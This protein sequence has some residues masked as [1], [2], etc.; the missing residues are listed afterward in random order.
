MF[1]YKTFRHCKTKFLSM[2]NL[3]N[4]P[5][6]LNLFRYRMFSESQHKRVPL[7]K[8]WHSETRKLSMENLDNPIPPFSSITFFATGSF[9][10]HNTKEFPCDIFPAKSD[11]NFSTESPDTPLV[12]HRGFRNQKLSETQHRRFPCGSFRLSETKKVRWKSLVPPSLRHRVFHQRK[13]SET[14][15]RSFPLRKVPAL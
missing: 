12:I 10:K 7:R 8:I 11:K 6:I 14:P 13:F 3:D 15:H 4:P 9:L 1:P 5:P 2:E